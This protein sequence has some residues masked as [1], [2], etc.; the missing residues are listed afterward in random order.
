MRKDVVRAMAEMGVECALET[1][2]S[3]HVCVTVT[4]GE[5]TARYFMAGTPSD[6]RSLKNNLAGLRRLV[7]SM[8][9]GTWQPPHSLGHHMP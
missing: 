9:D 5:R 7:R 3:N 4:L 6:V 8:Q 2:R 1:R